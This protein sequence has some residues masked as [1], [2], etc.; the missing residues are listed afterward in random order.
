MGSSTLQGAGPPTF[1]WQR[2]CDYLGHGNGWTR[3]TCR[4]WLG[5]SMWAS[6]GDWLRSAA[7]WEEVRHCFR[8]CVGP[9]E[10]HTMQGAVGARSS[11]PTILELVY[12]FNDP[13]WIHLEAD[14]LMSRDRAGIPPREACR[15]SSPGGAKGV[16]SEPGE[17]GSRDLGSVWENHREISCFSI[18]IHLLLGG[19]KKA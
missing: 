4:Q 3:L 9:L 6:P 7:S 14:L 16:W 12:C 1:T 11:P 15:A 19:H 2:G 10:L 8:G 13:T 17:L 18:S 5:Q